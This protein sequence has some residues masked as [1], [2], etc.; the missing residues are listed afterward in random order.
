MGS[1]KKPVV[2][3][4]CTLCNAP[5]IATATGANYGGRDVSAYVGAYQ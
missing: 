5:A 4:E 1:F 3:G 2:S